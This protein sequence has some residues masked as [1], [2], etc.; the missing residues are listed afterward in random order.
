MADPEEE[1]TSD[2]ER[3]ESMEGV[4]DGHD[5]DSEDEGE[6][7]KKE[8]ELRLKVKELKKQLDVN[9]LYY[10]GHVQLIAALRDLFELEEARKA[11]QKMSE[12]YPLTPE[13]WLDWIRDEQKVCTSSDERLYIAELFDRAVKDYTSVQLWVEYVMFTLG[14]GDMVATRATGERALT[15]V[16]TH[17]AEGVLIWQVV[18]LV[19]KQIYAGLQKSGTIQSEQ[20]IK[21]Q[22]KQLHRIQGLLRRQMRVP[23]LNCDAESLLEEASEYFDGEVDP[24]MKEDLKKTQKK[25]NEKIP[26]EDDLL[27]AENDVDKLAGYRRYIAQTK[28]TDNPAA[29]QSL[30][31]RAVTD[32]CLDVGLWEEYVR[33]VMHQFPGLDYVVLPVCERSQRNCPWS[34]TLCD[35]HIT[36]LQMFA[37]KEDESLTA[38]VKGAL[39]KGLSCGIQSGREATRMWMAYLIYLRRQIVWDQP[40]DCQL[41]AFRE[42]GQQAISMIDEYFGED[43]DIE[44]EIPRFLARIEAECAHDAERAREIWNDIIMKRNNNFKNAKLWLEFISLERSYGSEKHCRKLFRRALERVWDW[45]EEI[46]SAYLRFE[47]D[48]GTLESMEDFKKRYE[49]RLAIVNKK[50]AEDAAK[51]EAEKQAENEISQG[52]TQKEKINRKE[53]NKPNRA[54]N[55]R[56]SQGIGVFKVP[57]P[58]IKGSKGFKDEVTPSPGFKGENAPPPGFKGEITPPPGFKGE[59]A[60]PPGFKGEITPPPGFKGEVAPPPG[61]IG[62]VPPPSGFK[63]DDIPPP[64]FKDDVEPPPGFQAQVSDSSNA[65]KRQAEDSEDDKPQ[66]KKIKIEQQ[67]GVLTELDP[68]DELCTV[69]LSNLEFTVGKEDIVTIFSNC[70]EIADFRLVKDF[71]CRSKGFG[72]LVFKTHDAAVKSLELDRTLINGRPVFVSPYDPGNHGKKFRYSTGEEKDKLFVRGLPFSMTENEIRE[73]FQPHG[74]IKALRLVT[75]R[76]GH[77]KGTCYIDYHDATTAEKVQKAMNGIE[78]GGKTIS[79]LISDPSVKKNPSNQEKMLDEGILGGGN[80]GKKAF[81]S[82]GKG[83]FSLMPRALLRAHTAAGSSETPATETSE[84]KLSNED[85]RNMLLKK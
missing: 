33:F 11:R 60:P 18:L 73:I 32:H 20:E 44:S 21:E 61:F 85:F 37:S 63:D 67:Y 30:Y 16:G 84:T 22:E 53:R 28:E 74:E 27:R 13:L 6:Q 76:N 19:E 25:L 82:R 81:G 69:F 43:G 26:F 62:D 49:D 75:F 57:L 45:V 59:N 5:T 9:N 2:Q 78:V 72:Y 4:S 51:L 50:R 52:K 12:V 65:S 68:K 54:K 14:S 40:H 70:G 47:Q 55:S 15:A 23:L 48:V 3:E 77:S 58:V 24:H 80:K 7:D 8:E 38:K 10:D 83:M 79:V 64:G 71:K 42:A 66:I 31:E 46:G 29:V 56:Q 35:L 34:A 17:V 1:M 36:A 41:L 39:E